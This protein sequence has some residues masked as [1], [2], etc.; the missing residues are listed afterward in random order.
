MSVFSCL[1]ASTAIA[2]SEHHSFDY[3]MSLT[4]STMYSS[5]PD[6]NNNDNSQ[7]HIL[8]QQNPS[9][10]AMWCQVQATPAVPGTGCPLV[11]TKH[12]MCFTADGH[13]YLYGGRSMANKPLRDL[14]RFDTAQ[15]QWEE[16]VPRIE[17][18]L[19]RHSA[20]SSSS[21]SSSMSSAE[22]SPQ[23]PLDNKYEPPPALQEH[24][25]V[26]AKVSRLWR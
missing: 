18:P 21:S 20:G 14:W 15:D 17:T 3:I 5:P 16:V 6:L 7:N 13:I 22:S 26:A 11:R 2:G 4:P 24:T 8:N 12:A 10:G 19:S 25:I 1:R 23:S 9:A